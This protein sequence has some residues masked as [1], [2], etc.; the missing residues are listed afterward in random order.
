MTAP[1]SRPYLCTGQRELG[2]VQGPMACLMSLCRVCG[3]GES[4]EAETALAGDV[5][6]RTRSENNSRATVES[7]ARTHAAKEWVFHVF[8]TA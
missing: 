5:V 1:L 7:P 4:I 6:G 3:S 2:G 8:D